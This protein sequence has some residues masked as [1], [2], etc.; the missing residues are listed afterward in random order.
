MLYET[1]GAIEIVQ[2]LL[3]L[4]KHPNLNYKNWG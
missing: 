1:L 3:N 4:Q 2:Q